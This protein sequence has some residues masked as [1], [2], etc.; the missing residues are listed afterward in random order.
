MLQDFYLRDWALCLVSPLLRRLPK[1]FATPV[2]ESRCCTLSVCG[3]LKRG[4]MLLDSRFLL[5]RNP[6]VRWEVAFEG[7]ETEWRRSRG[8]GE[9]TLRLLTCVLTTKRT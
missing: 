6:V 2:D 8:R 1:A 3:H 4:K 5:V 7:P 9:R